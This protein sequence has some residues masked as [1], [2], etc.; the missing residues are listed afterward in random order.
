LNDEVMPTGILSCSCASS[1]EIAE[2]TKSEKKTIILVIGSE[3]V[4]YL[5]YY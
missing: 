3:F 2:M 4:V 1:S 5:N